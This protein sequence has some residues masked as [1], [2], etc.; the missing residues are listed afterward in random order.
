MY[1]NDRDSMRRVY[2]EAWRKASNGEAMDSMERLIAEVV[3]E[4]PEYQPLLAPGNESVLARDYAPEEGQTNPFLHMGLHIALR[5]QAAT[6]RPA[7][8]RAL[9]DQ[10]TRHTGDRL[11]AE[12]RLMEPLGE[13][14]WDAQRTA[15]EPDQAA[16]VERVRRLVADT[17]G[18]SPAA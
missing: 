13:A 18:T 16:Y 8:I 11:E 7:G 15:G 4:H 2:V 9:I 14:L 17:T 6:D 5:E 10:L 1:G 3:G 12:H